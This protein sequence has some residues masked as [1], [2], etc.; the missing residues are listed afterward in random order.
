M[1]LTALIVALCVLT[2]KG[3]LHA[4][5]GTQLRHM[6]HRPRRLQFANGEP[7]RPSCRFG[8]CFDVAFDIIQ[9]DYEAI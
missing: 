5:V 6:K 1:F 7:V 9:K 8:P 4:T 2:Q 3:A